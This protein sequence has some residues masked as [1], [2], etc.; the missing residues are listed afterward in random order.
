MKKILIISHR[1]LDGIT[2]AVGYVLNFLEKNNLSKNFKNIKACSDIVDYEHKEDIFKIL[3]KK[4]INLKDYSHLI[5]TD[6]TFS[7]EIMHSFYKVFKNNLIWIDHH[8]RACEDIE[9]KFSDLKIKINGLRDPNYSASYLV[10]KFFKKQ[11]A[12]EF[13]EIVQQVDLWSFKTP[14]YREYVA[15]INDFKGPFKRENIK[16]ILN[17]MDFETFNKDKQ[18]IINKGKIIIEIQNKN[19]KEQLFS[20]KII[21]FFGKKAFIIN[22][23]YIASVFAEV[24]F[25]QSDKKYKDVEILIIWYKEYNSDKFKFSLRRK[26]DS[27]VDLSKIAQEFQGGGHPAASGFTLNSLADFKY[28]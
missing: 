17:K 4:K 7:F 11:K 10:W 2:S 18:E 8:K 22:S 15:G 12:P 25:N 9:K 5:I 13:V 21:T 3:S 20:G 1:D 27:K 6:L 26:K 14:G 16:Y 24:F 23:L 19:I 28:G